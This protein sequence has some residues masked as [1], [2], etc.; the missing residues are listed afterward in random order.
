MVA[1]TEVAVRLARLSAELQ[2]DEDALEARAQ[3]VQAL[4]ERWTQSGTLP[5]AELVLLAVNL[6]GWYTALETVLERVARLLDQTV[7]TGAS[8]HT[9]LLAQMQ[10]E[11]PG[12]RP[13]VIPPATLRDLH[14]LRK[15]RHFFRNAYVLDLDPA[16]V[17]ERA[18]ELL[19]THAAIASALS[20]LG[21]HLRRTLGALASG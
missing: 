15:F 6:H 19:R 20:R 11:I 5:R 3:E 10:I 12:V 9:E 18:A 17:R 8:W 21:D 16:R 1:D 14:E 7:P 2:V 4:V 13:A